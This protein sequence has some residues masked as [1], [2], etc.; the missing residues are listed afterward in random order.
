VR[1]IPDPEVNKN[2]EDLANDENLGAA[3][4]TGS[5][6]YEGCHQLATIH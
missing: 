3:V 6:S 4:P 1:A 2:V 5:K